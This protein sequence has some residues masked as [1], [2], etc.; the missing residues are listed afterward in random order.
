MLFGSSHVRFFF[1]H[2]SL[3][4]LVHTFGTCFISTDCAGLSKYLFFPHRTYQNIL[5]CIIPLKFLTKQLKCQT[6]SFLQCNIV[7]VRCFHSVLPQIQLGAKRRFFCWQNC[8]IF[9]NVLCYFLL[10]HHYIISKPQLSKQG[11]NHIVQFP[12][13][14]SCSYCG[15]S[16][17]T[18]Q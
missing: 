7:E 4:C 16:Q 5:F 8:I 18:S 14:I 10:V 3:Y 15:T 2:L 6:L 12:D 11:T 9:Q 17:S 13:F 1:P